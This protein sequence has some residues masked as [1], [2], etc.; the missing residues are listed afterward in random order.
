MFYFKKILFLPVDRVGENVSTVWL[1]VMIELVDDGGIAVLQ[2]ETGGDVAVSQ[3]VIVR[4]E[5]LWR[6]PRF[7]FLIKKM[8]FG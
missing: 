2:K 1:W 6:G 8:Y 7:H 3:S 4:T 5:N